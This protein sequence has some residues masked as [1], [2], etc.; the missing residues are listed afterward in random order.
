MAIKNSKK[1]IILVAQAFLK[2]KMAK[3]RMRVN[4]C[5]SSK[6]MRVGCHHTSS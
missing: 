6:M 1:D 2:K 3:C 4:Y 5:F